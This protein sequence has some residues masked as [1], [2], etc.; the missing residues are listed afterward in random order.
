MKWYNFAF[1]VFTTVFV[2]LQCSGQ[3]EENKYIRSELKKEKEKRDSL[4][5]EIQTLKEERKVIDSSIIEMKKYIDIKEKK[6][7]ISIQSIKSKGNVQVRNVSD[8]SYV[9]LLK[10]LQ[11]R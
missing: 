6:L 2:L 11:P 5:Q 10:E 8:S 3:K 7:A 1:A 4:V 9:A